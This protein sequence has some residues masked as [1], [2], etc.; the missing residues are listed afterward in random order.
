M[1][2]NNRIILCRRIMWQTHS[3]RTLVS[4]FFYDL[5]QKLPTAKDFLRR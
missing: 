5:T 4:W 2:S 1:Q 3:T